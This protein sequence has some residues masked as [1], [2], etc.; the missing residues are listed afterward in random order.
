M[1]KI[2][3]VL[4]A[5][6][7]QINELVQQP[8]IAKGF[9]FHI[10][11]TMGISVYNDEIEDGK[12]FLQTA[13]IAFN[14]A[15]KNKQ[16]FVFYHRDTKKKIYENIILENELRHA[17]EK[18]EL[19]LHYQ[20]QVNLEN[21]KLMGLEALIRWN[22]PEKGMIPPGK[23]IPLAEE[24]GLIVPIGKW[25]LEEA[26]RQMKAW[27]NQGYPCTRISINLSMRQFFQDD[28]VEIVAAC[29]AK[30]RLEP[31][32]IEL[33]ITE[34]MTMDVDRAISMLK[35][36]KELGVRIAIDDFGTGYSSF[37][38]LHLFPVDQLKIDQSFIR[39]LS[40]DQANEAIVGTIISLG[41]HLKLELM[42]E[43]VE[44]K[45]QADFL[46]N[47]SCHGIQGYLIS[48]PLPA[49]EIEMLFLNE[50]LYDRKKS[51]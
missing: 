31:H 24:S 23:F 3:R 38:N 30:H 15:K 8:L 32:Y 14:E 27:L 40:I 33:E 19:I 20:P 43:G 44:T 25:V 37:S 34:S 6:A 42:A 21:G 39:N 5:L 18:E 13:T 29:L 16:P 49:R 17:I 26:C 11:A 41:R 2:L 9:K 28:L 4:S 51:S 45:E 46:S 7:K 22:H 12:H 50:T 36:F 1:L 10:D 48:R 35:K 47:R